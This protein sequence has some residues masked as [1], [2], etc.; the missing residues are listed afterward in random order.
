MTRRSFRLLSHRRLLSPYSKPRLDTFAGTPRTTRLI[1]LPTFNA[2]DEILAIIISSVTEGA[3]LWS[4]LSPFH[5]INIVFSR[6]TDAPSSLDKSC[7]TRCFSAW[8]YYLPIANFRLPAFVDESH[9]IR[10]WPGRWEER[11]IEPYLK[12][13]YYCKGALVN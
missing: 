12:R 3:I 9:N 11:E 2:K 6:A 1:L 10:R 5:E 13:L 8:L 7:L 4:Y